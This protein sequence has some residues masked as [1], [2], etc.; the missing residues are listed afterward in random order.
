[1]YVA[2][3]GDSDVTWTDRNRVEMTVDQQAAVDG[4]M[5]ADF[6]NDV[7][8][9]AVVIRHFPSATGDAETSRRLL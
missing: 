2:L 4:C 3:T 9:A 5:R 7:L 6:D 8:Y 1:M